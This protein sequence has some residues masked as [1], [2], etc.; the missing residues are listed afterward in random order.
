MASYGLNFRMVK[1]AYCDHYIRRGLKCPYCG[2]SDAIANVS[3]TGLERL[4]GKV[5]DFWNNLNRPLRL[6][7]SVMVLALILGY[8]VLG[9][10]HK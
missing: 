9:Y 3:E 1:C 4:L 10:P 7:L 8:L 2:D 5:E 6:L